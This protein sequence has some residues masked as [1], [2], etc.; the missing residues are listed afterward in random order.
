MPFLPSYSFLDP[1]GKVRVDV[2]ETEYGVSFPLVFNE[3]VCGGSNVLER[4]LEDFNSKRKADGK[5]NL[6]RASLSALRTSGALSS[7]SSSLRAFFSPSGFSARFDTISLL[8]L[9]LSV[10]CNKLNDSIS[11]SD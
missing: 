2:F 6:L 10:Y 4:H 7:S 11:T 3:Y 8:R 9:W 1:P 5:V